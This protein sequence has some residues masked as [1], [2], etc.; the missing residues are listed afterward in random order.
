[1]APT[2]KTAIVATI[3]PASESEAMLDELLRAGM[4]VLR[5]NFSHGDFAEH[6]GKVD[7]LR[8]AI[9][10]TGIPA[11]VLQDLSGPKFRIGDFYK[12]RVTLVEGETIVLTPE[13]I[14]GDE[15]RV[16]LNYPTLAEE[17]QPGNIVMV[18]DGKKKFEVTEIKGKEV[19]CKIIVGGETKGRRSVNLPGAN[20]KISSLTPKDKADLEFGF[21]NNVDIVAFS[22]VRRPEDVK[23]LRAILKARGSKAKIC[24]KIETQ[25]AIVPKTFDEIL[26]LSD[27]IMIGRGDLAVEVGYENVPPA[28]KMIIK[29][30]NAAGKF[31][32][33]ATQMLESMIKNP[34]PTRAEVSDVANAI[35]DGTDAIMLSEETT[36]GEYPVEAVEMMTKIAQRI[37]GDPLYTKKKF[38][39][40]V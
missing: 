31:V 14:I 27:M 34:V 33:T 1:M 39:S 13:K 18:D 4:N 37:E 5:A 40:L 26:A 2:K 6:Q 21:A 7:N 28:Q 8:K 20:L 11:L 17:L 30:C 19:V 24:A 36:L 15:K 25:E 35:L 32:I 10:T 16:S 22:F 9:K 12:E 23:E 38:I 3:G 29:K